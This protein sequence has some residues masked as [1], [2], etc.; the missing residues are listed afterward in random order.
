[1]DGVCAD[2][3]GPKEI[4][5][6]PL[7]AGRTEPLLDIDW[8]EPWVVAAVILTALAIVLGVAKVI[9]WI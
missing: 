5:G 6:R 8:D 9:G 7:R 3:W 4:R 2:C 1:V